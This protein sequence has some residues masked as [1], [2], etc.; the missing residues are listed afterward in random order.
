M[1]NDKMEKY[2]G[3]YLDNR[4]ELLEVIG[5]GGMA[6]VFKAMCHRLN[7]FVAVKI[8][9]EDLASNEEFRTRFRAESKS[10]AMLSHPNIVS[11]YDVNHSRSGEYIVMELVDGIT[12][13]QYL[14]GKNGLSWKETLHFSTQIAKALSHAH[15]KGLVHRDIKPHNIMVVQDGMIKVADFGIANLEKEIPASKGEAI[16]SVHYISPEQAKGLPVDSRSDIY[17][18]GIVMYEMLS[19]QLPFDGEDDSAIAMKHLTAVPMPLRELNPDI[20]EELANIVMKAMSPSLDNRYQ[21]ADE[22]YVDLER[23]RKSMSTNVREEVTGNVQPIRGTMEMSREGYIRR[24][25]R[26]N[27]VSM[28]SGFFGVLAFILF[29]AVFLWNYWLNDIFSTAKRVDIPNFVGSNYD[30]IIN[31]KNFN[32]MFNF[33]LTY[34]INPEVEK[35]VIINQDPSPGKSYMLSDNGIDISLVISTGVMLTDIPDYT[36]YD[37]REAVTA[38]EKLGFVVEKI[39]EPSDS[40][41]T[42]YI[43]N[44]SPS[45]GEKLPAGATVYVTISLGP[46]VETV[47]MPYLIGKTQ[48]YAEDQIDSM[49]LTLVTVS[50]VYSDTIAEGMVISQNVEAGTEIPIHSKIYLQVSL[51]PEPTPIPSPTPDPTPEA[52]EG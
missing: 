13:K 24:R 12:L 20:P 49:N 44:I 28:L 51:G 29:L 46:E 3:Q 32:E 5:S 36:N 47:I 39:F 2:L 4:Y 21:T 18:L 40:V 17:S 50:P 38:L 10:V 1:D 45:P 41:T 52:T 27:R 37:Y 30:D 15:S 9:R 48:W 19:G 43:I 42:D 22:M 35:G 8:M 14:R 25:I 31:S 6:V 23:F 26:A 7:R 11:V 16:G 34:E 33:S